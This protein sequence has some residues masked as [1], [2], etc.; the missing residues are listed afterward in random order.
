MSEIYL[1]KLNIHS[2]IIK[3]LDGF[4]INQRIPHILFHGSSGT[5]KRTLVYDFVNKIFVVLDLDIFFSASG[6]CNGL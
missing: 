5:G 2:T 1:K 3:K 4:I 6:V